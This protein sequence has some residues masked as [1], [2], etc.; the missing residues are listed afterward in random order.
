MSSLVVVGAQWGDEGKGKLVDFL[1]AKAQ[2][3]VRFQGGNN[4][5]HT[6][7]VDGRK[8]KL[9]LVPSG[10]LRSGCRCVIAAGVVIDPAVLLE[11]IATL[12]AA[13][14]E[15]SPDKLLIDRDT[16]LIMPYHKAIDLARESRR[17]ENKIGTT[18]RGIGPAYE[19]RAH[20][21]GIRAAELFDLGRLKRRYGENV[22]LANSYLKNVLGSAEVVDGE[23]EWEQ[24]SSSAAAIAPHIGNASKVLY[25]ALK[26]GERM[27]FEGAQGT[28]LDQTFG[29]VPFVTSS[30]TLAGAVTIG[31][32]LGP[33]AVDYVLGVAKS[34]S[35]RV[36]AGPFPTELT[37]SV[38][39]TIRTNGHE[40]GTVTGRPRR[41]GWMDA[42]ALRRAVRLNGIDSL[43]VTK[44]DVLAGLD[45][46]KICHAYRLDGK[47]ID[48]MP[49]LSEEIER[50]EPIYTEF[51]GWGSEIVDAKSWSDL[52]ESAKSYLA[53][54]SDLTACSISIVSLGPEREAT[55]F[56]K[57]AAFVSKFIQ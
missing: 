4:A 45:T 35:T 11:E 32:G 40:F 55:V 28:L 7:V 48:D 37:D 44:L 34:Y 6:L 38:G 16:H 54:L 25:E 47:E 23:K 52:P 9:S 3:V 31:C 51:S 36:G 5:G 27:M 2:W 41:C 21:V 12:R 43:A 10:V 22:E 20:R 53:A 49:A 56:S 24:L 46:V 29:T 19:D 42:V 1:T 18:G 17:G 33:R 26:R 50:V 14:I 30:H 57:D 13:G 39:D 8:F 15:V